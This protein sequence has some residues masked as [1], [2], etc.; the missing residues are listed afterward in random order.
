MESAVSLNR[1][2]DPKTTNFVSLHIMIFAL[3]KTELALIARELNRDYY[4][5]INTYVY[6][7]IC[8]YINIYIYNTWRERLRSNF[9]VLRMFLLTNLVIFLS[10]VL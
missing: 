5:Y 10:L 6:I 8:I 1:L 9:R 2:S 3:L 7:Y 4:I